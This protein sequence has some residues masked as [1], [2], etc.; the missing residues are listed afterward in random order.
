[1][2]GLDGVRALAVI[3]VVVYHANSNWLSGGFFGVDLFFVIS[4]YLITSI[5]V[6]ERERTGTIN[7]GQFW[8]RRARRL[9]P[10][11]VAL[12]VVVIAVSTFVS[13]DALSRMAGDVPAALFY[14]TNWWFI[15]HKDS[16]FAAAGRP[17]LFQHL[18]SLAIEEQFYLVWPLILTFV[19]PRLRRLRSL[20]IGTAV[21]AVLS[22]ALMAVLFQPNQDASHA[23]TTAPTPTPRGC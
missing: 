14:V 23:C 21:A 2:V 10:A 19:L 4:G 1:M 18:W 22:T 6:R 7:L 5:V 16:Y 11:V 8:L 3:A 12:L 17:P 15:F 9:F 20:A 13:P